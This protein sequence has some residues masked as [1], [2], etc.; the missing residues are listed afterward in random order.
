MAGSGLLTEL[1]KRLSGKVVISS[2]ISDDDLKNLDVES[3]TALITTHFSESESI[4]ILDK[5]TLTNII[6]KRDDDKSPIEIE[7]SSPTAFKPEAKDIEAR[8]VISNREAERTSA[9]V[10][11]FADYF[12]DRFRNL[13]GKIDATRGLSILHSIDK[14]KE[15]ADG[16]ELSISGMVYEKFV[17]KKGNIMLTLEDDTGSAKVI[18]VK[19]EGNSSA[20]RLFESAKKIAP[21]SVIAVR[22]KLSSPFLIANQILWPDIPIRN[23]KVIDEKISIAF[24][25][26]VHIGSKLFLEKQFGRFIEWLNG[27]IDVK[28]KLAGSIKYLVI[29]G[30]LVDGIG[31]YPEQD[32]ELSIPDIYKQYSMLF[33]LLSKIP[34]YIH[35]FILTGNHDAVQRA[36]PQPRLTDDLIGDFSQDN[37]HLVSNPG[38][39]MLHGLKVLAYHGTSLDSVIRNVPGCS[40]DKPETAMVEM[41]KMRHLS[42]VYG[43]NPIVPNKKDF[44]AIDE[45]PDILHMGHM[46]KNGYTEY[47]G[48]QIINS[49]T[50][51]SRTSYQAKLGH[52]P[53]PAVLPV[54]E[55][56]KG[57]LDQID[58]NQ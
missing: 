3:L 8:F 10:E 32:K 23:K 21:D 41:L 22:G 44:M 48:T 26:D 5:E 24:T 28:K 9:S 34:D 46:H 27:N 35:T 20:G 16:R 17:T 37:I 39:L 43:D 53:T 11:A 4:S 31:V 18:F 58:F 19:V 52:F 13:R 42:P 12:N 33:N 29:S 55:C 30:D 40:T 25:S 47:H 38:S 36:E 51:Q 50:W 6:S 2:D 45:I 15:Y 7:I 56:S 57:T 14:M 54:Y 1:A 49:G